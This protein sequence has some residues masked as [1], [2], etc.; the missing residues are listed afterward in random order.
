MCHRVANSRAASGDMCDISAVVEFNQ[1]FKVT[2]ASGGANKMDNQLV[3]A[4][5]MPAPPKTDLIVTMASAP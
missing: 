1:S 3:I 5:A 2:F 4:I